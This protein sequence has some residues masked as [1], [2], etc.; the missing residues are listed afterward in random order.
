LWFQGDSSREVQKTDPSAHQGGQGGLGEEPEIH[1]A[2]SFAVKSGRG[3]TVQNRKLV[4]EYD[5]RAAD[6]QPCDLL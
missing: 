1:F 4:I 5:R 6:V 2:P 3:E